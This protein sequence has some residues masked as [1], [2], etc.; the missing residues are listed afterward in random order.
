MPWFEGSLTALKKIAGGIRWMGA[1][2]HKIAGG[3]THYTEDVAGEIS[4]W[5]GDIGR[6]AWVSNG[7]SSLLA[8]WEV[9]LNRGARLKRDVSGLIAKWEV[10]LTKRIR[11]QIPLSG[12]KAWTA[13]GILTDKPKKILSGS[14]RF[15][16]SL[17]DKPKELLDGSFRFVGSLVDK[18]LEALSG[19]FRLLGSITIKFHVSSLLQGVWTATGDIAKRIR[20]RQS[21]SGLLYLVGSVAWES[22]VGPKTVVGLISKMRGSIARSPM[23]YTR[24]ISREI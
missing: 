9:T 6:K 11:L 16:G 10:T 1:V 14:F 2:T 17:V 22:P 20:I 13:S 8:K 15:V 4:K 24:T 23:I 18:S 12:I 3:V 21:V 19:S 7:L 5:A